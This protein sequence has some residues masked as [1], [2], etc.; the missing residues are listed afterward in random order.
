MLSYRI[1]CCCLLS[2][3]SAGWFSNCGKMSSTCTTDTS[4]HTADY[5][6]LSAADK[7]GKLMANVLEDTT[8]ADWFSPLQVAGMF[9]EKM[10][11]TFT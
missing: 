7:A 6:G 5:L 4:V 11:P 8:S 3:V 9:K 1:I 2:S 10:C